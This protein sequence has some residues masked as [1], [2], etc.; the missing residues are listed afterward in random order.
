MHGGRP[1]EPFVLTLAKHAHSSM[2]EP[3]KFKKTFAAAMSCVAVIFAMVANVC[4]YA[5]GEVT[6][7]SI[8]AFLLEKYKD[9][10]SMIVFLMIANT[11]VSLS[12][13]FTY[14]L[15][16][17]PTFELAGPKANAF[18]WKFWHGGKPGQ[19]GENDDDEH[20]LG[21][22]DPMPTLHEDEVASLSS[23]ENELHTYERD[24]TE[25]A[26]NSDNAAAPNTD[27]RSSMV[28]NITDTFPTTSIPGDSLCLRSGLVLATFLVAVIVPNV[29]VLISLAGAVAG[30]STALLI[31]P[32]LELALIDHLE[33][34]PDVNASTKPIPPSQMNSQN[35]SSFKRLCR[36]DITGRYWKKKLKNLLLFWLGFVF[37]LIGAYASISDIVA[38]WLGKS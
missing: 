29:Q 8:T 24:G 30:S 19:I 1:A 21:G 9:D 28:S 34:K 17:F 36:C 26:P 11:A 10:N 3:K 32:M 25:D 15:M 2:G 13:L 16:L 7:G 6:N 33:S 5:F 20:D 12:V 35:S 14:P 31:P 4:V 37:M 22:F 23:H 18:W 27:T 38:I